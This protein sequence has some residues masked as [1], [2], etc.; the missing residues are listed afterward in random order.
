MDIRTDPS[1]TEADQIQWFG[2]MDCCSE[3]DRPQ[4]TEDFTKIKLVS[5]TDDNLR[6]RRENSGGVAYFT[7]MHGF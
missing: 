5:T 6:G 4:R 2:T 3:R 7:G 1:S